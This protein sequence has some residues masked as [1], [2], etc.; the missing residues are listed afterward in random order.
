M[1]SGAGQDGLRSGHKNAKGTTKEGYK[2]NSRERKDDSPKKE[3]QSLVISNKLVDKF[4]S[5]KDL[6]E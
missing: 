2:S 4:N 1:K 3:H 6:K 5:G